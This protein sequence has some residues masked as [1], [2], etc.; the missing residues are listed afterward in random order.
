MGK[1]RAEDQ[2]D[3][4]AQE[5][6]DDTV[7]SLED[8]MIL[9]YVTNRPVKDT[10]KEKVRQRIARAFFHEYGI[11]VDDME[12]NFKMQVDGRRR[13]IDLAIFEHD[14]PHEVDHLRRV[15]ICEKEPTNGR[16]SAYRM[17]SPEEAEKEF[18]LLKDAMAEAK[19]CMFGL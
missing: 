8:G 5:S 1:S 10:P 13:K 4:P 2:D 3:R 18:E 11:A 6:S 7:M 15:V 12:P 19:N 9:D 14:Q 16:K 17:R